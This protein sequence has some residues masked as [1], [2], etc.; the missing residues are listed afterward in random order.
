[1]R[2]V[3]S[4]LRAL[5]VEEL[6]RRVDLHAMAAANLYPDIWGETAIFNEYVPRPTTNSAPSMPTQCR[7]TKRSSRSSAEPLGLCPALE[8]WAEFRHPE[9]P[10]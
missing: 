4:T 10:P 7:K 6:R 5:P 1:M 9:L 3:A 2:A 8:P